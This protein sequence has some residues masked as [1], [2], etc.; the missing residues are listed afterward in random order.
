MKTYIIARDEYTHGGPGSLTIEIH[1]AAGDAA[2][3]KQLAGYRVT[4]AT[5]EEANGDGQDYLAISELLPDST[6]R[7]IV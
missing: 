1:Q 3:L 5:F 7:S 2:L 6:L 4:L